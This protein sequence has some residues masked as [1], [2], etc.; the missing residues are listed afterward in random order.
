MKKLF[1][2]IIT[3]LGTLY[4]QAQDNRRFVYDQKDVH[5][6]ANVTIT[7]RSKKPDLLA[8]EY[9][10][11]RDNNYA[12]DVQHN[13]GYNKRGRV[14]KNGDYCQVRIW[15]NYGYSRDLYVQISDA[16][17]WSH[18]AQD[19]LSYESNTSAGV[20]ICKQQIAAIKKAY[21]LALAHG[22]VEKHRVKRYVP[23]SYSS[24]RV[25]ENQ[26]SGYVAKKNQSSGN[27]AV[28]NNGV[29]VSTEPIHVSRGLDG[30]NYVQQGGYA[31]LA[32]KKKQKLTGIWEI[33]SRNIPL[34][35]KYNVDTQRTRW[36]SKFLGA[37]G[38]RTQLPPVVSGLID[39]VGFGGAGYLAYKGI[40]KIS[41][42]AGTRIVNAPSPDGGGDDDGSDDGPGFEPGNTPNLPPSDGN[43]PGFSSRQ[44]I[45][46]VSFSF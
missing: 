16:L 46:P 7:G 24:N 13:S 34:E 10:S 44:I 22:R 15:N 35:K 6:P 25:L 40:K 31:D 36:S 12:A 28:G 19:A 33:D 43:G 17:E 42:G 21:R 20:V 3:V 45:S 37:F 2:C 14:V 30:N 5:V 38:I 9:S 39:V 18:A 41:S 1:F 11:L 23:D 4:T 27:S 32:A 29:V 26:S 8:L